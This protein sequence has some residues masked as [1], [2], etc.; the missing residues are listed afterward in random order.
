MKSNII[1]CCT[2]SQRPTP[3]AWGQTGTKNEDRLL[4]NAKSR[5]EEGM[6]EDVALLITHR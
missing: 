5:R 3:P 6:R 4:L 1:R 2:N